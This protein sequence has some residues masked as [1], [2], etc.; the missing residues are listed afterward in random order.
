[1]HRAD[2][3]R[4]QCLHNSIYIY[5]DSGKFLVC[6]VEMFGCVP[7]PKDSMTAVGESLMRACSGV[8]NE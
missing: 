8:T 1:M 3:G 2:S 4:L 6:I 7:K 5:I